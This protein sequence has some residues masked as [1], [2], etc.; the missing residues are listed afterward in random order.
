[1]ATFTGAEPLIG[2]F[3][4]F[5]EERYRKDLAELK[6][7]YPESRSFY[8][9]YKELEKFDPDLADEILQRPDKV[10]NAAQMALV[11]IAGEM[12]KKFEPHVRVTD[13]PDSGLLVQEIGAAQIQRM[14]RIDG[15]VTKRAEVR[16]RVKIAVY[17]C[18][19]CDSIFKIPIEK[20]TY[21]PDTCENCHK[22]A[23]ELDED[24]SYFVD[25]QRSEM[26]ELLERVRGGTPAATIELIIEDDLVNTIIPG[27]TVEITGIVRIRPIP[28]AKTQV[29]AKFIDV[30]SMKNVQR[31]FEEV[32]LKKEDI[33][34]ILEFA[35]KP[36]TFDQIVKAIAPSIYGHRE[37]KE[38][39]A[40]QIFGG[41][42]EKM[43]P[44]GGRI[45]S[46]IHL[47]LIG[48]PGVSKTRLIQ[49]M[50][51]LAPKSVYVSG[52]SVTGA[53]LTASAERDEGGEGWTLK[54]G[55]LVLASGGL[56]SIDEFDK[57][58][59][60]E[61]AALHE[62]MESQSYHP[63]TKLLLSGG[64]EV[65][66]GSFVE[67]LMD[68]NKEKVY[69]GK[70]CLILDK[71]LEGINVLTTDFKRIYPT[72]ISQVSK[73]KAP[74]YYIKVTLINGR[75]LLVTPEHPF[76]SI[77][78]G[79]ITTKAASEI[80][81]GD[82]TLMP[83]KLPIATDNSCQITDPSFFRFLGYHISD[84][85]YE[86]NRGKKNGI[87]F[88][89]KNEQIIRD[90]I[91][92]IDKFFDSRHSI[93]TDYRT[94][95]QMVRLISMPVVN[96]LKTLDPLLLEKGVLKALPSELMAAPDGCISEFLRAIFEGDGSI[97]RRGTLS[98]VCENVKLAEQVQTM[99]LRFGV[100]AHMIK[101]QKV[102]RIYATGEKNLSLFALHI[103]FIS[104]KKSKTLKHCINVKSR[105]PKRRRWT[106]S[107]AIPGCSEAIVRVMNTLKL[108]HHQTF[109]YVLNTQFGISRP[110]FEKAVGVL[111]KRLEEIRGLAVVIDSLDI[112]QI[113]AI[114]RKLRISQQDIGGNRLRSHIGYWER[115]SMMKERY[116]ALFRECCER[117]LAQ[118]TVVKRLEQLLESDISFCRIKK[119]EKIVDKGTDWVYDVGVRPT[120]AFISECAVLHNT[121]S[122]AKAGI[123]ARFKAR[124][125]ILAAAN[126]KFG[127][128]DPNQ[129]P[130]EQFEVPPTLLSR[131]DLIFPIRDIMDEEKDKS[132]AQYILATHRDAALKRAPQ[133][134]EYNVLSTEF[135]RK[136]IAYARKT[137]KPI[138]TPEASEKIKEYY[139]Q[140]RKLGQS[141]GAV[142]ITP[143]QIEGLI[144]LSEASAKTRLTSHVDIQ[145]AERA[146]RLTDFVLKQIAFD[147]TTGRIDIDIITTG[148]PRSRAE[149][150]Y[151]V[152]GVIRELSRNYDQ[153]SREM[154]ID[155]AKK[156]IGIDEFV[157]RRYLDD[158]LR[159]GEL[160]EPKPGFL[161][162]VQRS[163]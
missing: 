26:Q 43:L 37:V 96:R 23:L 2:K 99:L 146:I 144:R 111:R 89:N 80:R 13:L 76:W 61:Q 40:L 129:L 154:I 95:V 100:R 113:S 54:A 125:A 66:I 48:D 131:F 162:F 33:E 130:A 120:E 57:I 19:R 75:T 119:V 73:H 59:K 115:N 56:A 35:K 46:D 161:K 8:F 72:N 134:E 45:R 82:Y 58:D 101:D 114:R 92:T 93:R 132:L 70:D 63:S 153:V 6:A 107:E 124:T 139:V 62:V 21:L 84:G 112:K 141:Q 160:F 135:L 97:S 74:D 24:G 25:L 105:I 90:Y 163:E 156:Q 102:F 106:Y 104:D 18:T 86:L 137:V 122:V 79:Q 98:L 29:Y 41:T 145:D 16:P 60:I 123:V 67:E 77:S 3:E 44:E 118:E 14:I 85:G 17:H 47:L 147:R 5:F 39:L 34:D 91:K 150:Y 88:T 117:L 53:G 49:Y 149:Q 9:S 4:E 157:V 31:E 1:M 81:A 30:I 10:I 158:M 159:K 69:E 83:S 140:L 42:P 94:G 55:A 128:F 11:S 133:R 109:G 15:V 36:D 12:N 64:R 65:E 52:K 51:D 103:G 138:L 22:K 142:A 68:K 50:A 71:G 143:R 126:P 32:E 78:D 110:L 27:D 87:N 38:A 28:K 136:Y 7:K 116:K 20:G 121:V 127:R 108:T 152:V 155:E 148:Q 151:D